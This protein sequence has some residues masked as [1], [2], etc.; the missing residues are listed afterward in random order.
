MGHDF[1]NI[2]NDRIN[3]S[4]AHRVKKGFTITCPSYGKL[5]NMSLLNLTCNKCTNK[6]EALTIFHSDILHRSL[7]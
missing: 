6:Q 3:F 4:S 2:V 5:L 1:Q 7:S